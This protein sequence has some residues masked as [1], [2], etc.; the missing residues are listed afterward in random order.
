MIENIKEHIIEHFTDGIPISDE[1]MKQIRESEELSSYYRDMKWVLSETESENAEE[2]SEAYWESFYTELEPKLPKTK[3]T[4]FYLFRSP[5]VR[6]SIAACLLLICGYFAGSYQT[7]TSN[8]NLLEKQYAHTAQL[9]KLVHQSKIMLM[10]FT[11]MTEYESYDAHPLHVSLSNTL[12]DQ[13]KELRAAE[14]N[15]QSIDQLLSE[16]ERTLT[17]ISTSQKQSPA[18]IKMVQ[19]S[20]EQKKLLNKLQQF[21][22]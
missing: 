12:L 14:I 9:K 3:A 22:I 2:P 17:L 13:T 5:M 4:V 1:M 21:E 6:N 8:T 16:L 10:T 11:T 19:Y 20:V 18:H 15:D 7:N